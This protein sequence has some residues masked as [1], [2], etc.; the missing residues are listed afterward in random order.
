MTEL[1]YYDNPYLKETKA[2]C[3][4]VKENGIVLDKTIF[5][6]ECGGQRGDRGFFG[7]YKIANTMHDK[8]GD[9]IH[10][11]CGEKPRVG[12]EG[13]LVLDWE[14]RYLGMVLHSAQHLISAV[15]FNIF[16]IKTLS[17]HQGEGCVSIETDRNKI[18]EDEILS[19]EDKVNRVITENRKI[20]SKEYSR[21]DAEKLSLRRT[22]KVE[23]DRIRVVFIDGTD[24]VPCGGVHLLNSGEIREVSYSRMEE[25]R[26]H[27][28][29]FWNVGKAAIDE[30]LNNRN[31]VNRCRALLSSSEITA[32]VEKMLGENVS[33]K[34]RIKA[35]NERLAKDELL[36]NTQNGVYVYETEYPLCDIQEIFIGFNSSVFV[37]E[38]DKNNFIFIGEKE[39]FSS[40][41][42]SFP[43]KGGGRERMYRG[44]ILFDRD[45][46]L[47]GIK[48]IL[49]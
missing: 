22:I 9:V 30:K 42:K 34:K 48:E 37:S 7:K 15:M 47:N 29:L 3:V 16:G 4:K 17:V 21:E 18:E 1:L 39:V 27:V 28:R 46:V 12:E 2:K 43:L 38:K 36:N 11:I 45:K 31:I 13:D 26:N 40:L 44:V 24:S 6:A 19:I 20:W 32:E 33:L 8:D 35:L 41:L 14:N 23:G 10:L 25:I 5:Y 49:K